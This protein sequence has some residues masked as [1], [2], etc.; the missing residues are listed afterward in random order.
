MKIAAITITLNR[1][2]LTK[3]TF[4]SFYAKTKVDYHLIVD[5][6]S[7]DGTEKWIENYPHIKLGKNY[8]ISYAFTVGL[9]SLMT[10]FDYILKLDNDVETVTDEIIG[11]ILSFYAKA[12]NKYIISPV[13]LLIDPNFY[14]MVLRREKIEGYEVEFVSHTGGAFQVAPYEAVIK[15]CQNYLTFSKGD[16]MIGRFYQ[17]KGYSPVYLKDLQMK[18][19]GLN[20]GTPRETYK[21]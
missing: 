9:K 6:G 18:H 5:N 11:K 2:E 20:Q 12:G 14:P 7:T 21:M 8:G 16:Y 10:S 3:K 19:I 17:K 1:L 13:D 4:E 15:L